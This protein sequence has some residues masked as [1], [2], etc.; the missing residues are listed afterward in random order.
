MS[1]A[2]H[3][4]T[5]QV[6]GR[7][8]ARRARGLAKHGYTV[9]HGFFSGTCDGSGSLPVEEGTDKLDATVKTLRQRATAYEAT[10]AEQIDQVPIVREVRVGSWKTRKEIEW[11]SRDQVRRAWDWDR[12]TK[13]RLCDLRMQAH[14]MRQHI[15]T[16]ERLRAE[17]HGQ[18]L[19]PR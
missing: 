13:R 12:M 2:T 17:R 14:Q 8:Q 11:V 4:G 19:L 18:P 9:D 15:E 16:L 6:C 5:C 3:N 7:E 1:A 10:T